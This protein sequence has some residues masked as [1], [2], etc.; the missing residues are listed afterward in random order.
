MRSGVAVINLDDCCPS[1]PVVAL[2]R[3]FGGGEVAVRASR[4]RCVMFATLAL[5]STGLTALAWAQGPPYEG[6]GAS[7]PG[8]SA[9]SVVHVTT[10]AESGPGSLREAVAQGNRTIVFDVG[11]TIQLTSA[12][13]V[14]GAF[15][16]IDGFSAPPPGIT[17]QGGA[18]VIRGNQ[19][20]HD[21]IVRGIRVR[22]AP[23]DG[24]QIAL[25]AYN[26]VIDHVSISGAGDGNLDITDSAHDITVSWSIL[27][28]P[29][30]DK[31]MLIKYNAS[32]ISLHHNLFTESSQR[33]PTV[34]TDDAGTPATDTTMDMR[35]NVIWNWGFGTG[36][37]LFKGARS[38]V[39]ANFTSS[40]DS[41]GHIDQNQGVVVCNLDCDG[42]LTAHALGHVIDNLSGDALHI[43]MNAEA[44]VLDPFPAPAITVQD[45]YTAAQTVLAEAGV[46]PLDAFDEQL[47]T[48]IV[49]P[50]R[51]EGPNLSVSYLSVTTSP[52][53]FTIADRVTNS[54]TLAADPSTTRFVLSTDTVLDASDLVLD[55]RSV[56]PLAAGASSTGSVTVPF[57]QGVT[58]PYFLIAYA[59]GAGAVSETSELD[60]ATVR[61][62]SI[63]GPDLVISALSSGP[64]ANPGGSLSVTETTRNQGN[65]AV[66]ATATRY[67][68]STDAAW[69]AGDILLAAF[70][71]V[72]AL[73]AG[74]TH[75]KTTALT[76]PSGT[77]AGTY[78]VIARA[79]AD[80]GVSELSE[81]NNTA[82]QPVIVG[83]D[84]VLQSLTA[85]F[86]ATPG[87]IIKI[88]DT[89]KNI[90]AQ[91]GATTTRYYL[92]ADAL[93]GPGDVVLGSRTVPGLSS[94][95]SH[96]GPYISVTVP[97]TT[98]AGT[99]H[100]IARAEAD[101]LV[102][103]ADEA[104]NTAAQPIEIGIDLSVAVLTTPVAAVAGTTI[105]VTDT[106][107]NTGSAAAPASSTAFFI[108]TT[109]TLG[110]DATP[111]G[112]RAVPALAPNA[113]SAAT[114]SVGLPA[115]LGGDFYIIALANAD[116]GIGIGH[117]NNVKAK[118]V[119]LGPD[120]VVSALTAPAAAAAGATV[121]VS[122]TTRNTA[123]VAAPASTTTYFLSP[124]PSLGGSAVEVGARSVPPLAA[125]A[126]SAGPGRVTIPAGTTPG[127]YYLIAKGDGVNAIV[128]Y[129][130]TNN[131]RA[132]AINV[133]P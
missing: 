126:T 82:A 84:L 83:G 61:V 102:V 1:W 121:A 101:D 103:E 75:A 60:N 22:D 19:G 128:E 42:D 24:I 100:I 47:L 20:A 44:N 68:L 63:T 41:E 108:S 31:N 74:A 50:P 125:G 56:G 122:D 32:R 8:G 106:T 79:D 120:F 59:D 129:S 99:Y 48:N 116:A 104:N 25:G 64:A 6:F 5:W 70:H 107:R 40:P 73:A 118:L 113:S 67:Y 2:H 69:D 77:A 35:N 115:G 90:G 86:V 71:A 58:G 132:R 96:T 89:T 26:V 27:A 66:D 54:G 109:S 36:A 33:N 15:I 110:P 78:F 38:N 21:V 34:S 97:G 114:T 88:R 81:A 29:A 105:S 4:M 17:L 87:T 53:A 127:N 14:T 51:P 46:R 112:V 95:A 23:L 80:T 130:E 91:V 57:P 93:S 76:I 30:S 52:S 18:L 37:M 133:T 13:F 43:D 39:V 11:G 98:A 119:R 117:G 3:N 94:G 12:V 85:P 45:A 92:S 72:P 28:A 7:T 49:L 124:S 62:V 131:T 16:T 9:G 111:I 123:S 55:S 65:L 10:L